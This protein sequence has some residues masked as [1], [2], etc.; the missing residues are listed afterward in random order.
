MTTLRVSLYIRLRGDKTVDN[1]VNKLVHNPVDNRVH[2]PVEKPQGWYDAVAQHLCQ[3]DQSDNNYKNNDMYQLIIGIGQALQEGHTCLPLPVEFA[4]MKHPLV[5]DESKANLQPAPLVRAGD[6]VYFY[7]QWQQEYRLAEQIVRLLQPVRLQNVQSVKLAPESNVNE[8]QQQAIQLAC[9]HYF[10]LITGGP[11]TGKTYTLVR[12]VKRLQQLQANLRIALAAPTGKAAQR[13][14]SVLNHAFSSENV[15]AGFIHPAQTVHRLLGLGG[16]GQPRYH[17]KNPLPYDLIVLDEGSML[18]LELASQLFSAIKVGTR[19]IILGDADQLAAVE[20]GAVLADLQGSEVLKPYQIHLTE[21]Q[22]F[23]ADQGIGQLAFAVLQQQEYRVKSILTAANHSPDSELVYH[24][25]HDDAIKKNQQAQM[26]VFDQLWLGY[27]HYV[28]ALRYEKNKNISQLFEAFDR[29]RI[30][31]AMRAGSL[32]TERI[33]REMS[34]RLN[35]A[36]GQYSVGEWFQGRPVMMSRND[37]GLQLSNGD[38][39]ICLKDHQGH[40]QVYFPHLQQPIAVSRLPSSDISTAFALTIHKSQGSEFQHVAICLDAQA[41]AL[42]G[43]ELLYTAITRAREK[44]SLWASQ[45]TLNKAIAQQM[46]RVTG[47]KRQLSQ[48]QQQATDAMAA[49][50]SV[51]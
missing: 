20:A 33:N 8:L 40:W 24:V 22:R 48:C 2:N 37:Y 36:L 19:V 34:D 27:Q 41:Q 26:V 11:G 42:L 5:V 7:R 3:R 45:R 46:R 23:K 47:L 6:Y 18:D 17:A 39:G 35:M 12:I 32:G 29:Y 51:V 49:R 14:Q 10:S 9:T 44:V 21:S 13:M 25:I 16:F 15:H 28:A 4:H 50:S 38:I 1:S 30:L 43:R 31:A